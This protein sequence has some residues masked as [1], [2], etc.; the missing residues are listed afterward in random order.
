[1]LSKIETAF[2]IKLKPGE[3]LLTSEKKSEYIDM[4]DD[5]TN[6]EIIQ[7]SKLSRKEGKMTF[8]KL[9]YLFKYGEKR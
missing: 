7:L 5:F 2:D 3:T 4:L 9:F 1:M 8:N 6:R